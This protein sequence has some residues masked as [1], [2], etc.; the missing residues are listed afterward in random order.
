MKLSIS[1]ASGLLA[2]CSTATAQQNAP[3]NTTYTTRDSTYDYIVAGAGAAGIVAAERLASSGHTVLLIERGGTSFYSTGN[4]DVLEWNNTVTMYDVP[5]MADYTG[6]SPDLQYCKDIAVAA[7]CT[8][9]GSTM[10]NAMMWVKPR[11]AD[12]ASWPEEW[13]WDN[14]IA[15][16]AERLYERLPG[17]KLASADGKRYDNGAFD[18]MSRFLASNGW[19]E[20]DALNNVEAKEQMYSHPP[21]MVGRS[22]QTTRTNEAYKM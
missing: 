11:A 16:A 13:H 3:R 1:S 6:A 15:D 22:Y 10:L 7:G 14:G 9:G 21:W 18:I 20:D 4:R 5:G 19:T 2:L 8:L 17:T 12:F